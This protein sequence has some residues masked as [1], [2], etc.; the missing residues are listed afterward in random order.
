MIELL[1]V[2]LAGIFRKCRVIAVVGLSPKPARPSHQVTSYLID[3]G[4]EVIP[5]NPGQEEILGRK[6][7]PDLE[8]VPDQVDIVDVFRNA[9]DVPPI[10]DKAM[11]I[12]AKVVWL[13]QGIVHEQA[14]EKARRAGLIVVMDRCLKID[15]QNYTALQGKGR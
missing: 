9:R 5:V 11:A 8:Q 4:F 12:G 6:C 2:D 14:A 15:C 1:D 7:Y 13:Q 3:Q 10:I